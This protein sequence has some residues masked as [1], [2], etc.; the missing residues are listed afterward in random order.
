MIESNKC[1]IISARSV[2]KATRFS[3]GGTGKI[4]Q[5]QGAYANL[6]ALLTAVRNCRACESHLPPRRECIEVAVSCKP[7]LR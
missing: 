4:A 2:L 1:K 7:L 5:A 3:H 6:E